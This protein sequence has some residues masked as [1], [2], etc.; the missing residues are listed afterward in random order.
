MAADGAEAAFDLPGEMWGLS[1]A[2]LDTLLLEHARQTVPGVFRLDATCP[3]RPE[4]SD[5]PLVYLEAYTAELESDAESREAVRA[6]DLW[7]FAAFPPEV[8]QHF[9]FTITHETPDGR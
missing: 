4:L 8:Y 9:P 1:R 3:P 7:V 5:G 6:F 2:Q